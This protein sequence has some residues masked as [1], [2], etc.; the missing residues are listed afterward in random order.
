[1]RIQVLFLL[2]FGVQSHIDEM[3]HD[4]DTPHSGGDQSGIK[5]KIGAFQSGMGE[6][7]PPR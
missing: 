6:L 2:Q 1:M 7:E 3:L 5:G 4:Q